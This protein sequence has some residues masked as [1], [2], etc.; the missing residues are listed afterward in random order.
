MIQNTNEEYLKERLN[1]I[2][3]LQ[4]MVAEKQ[5]A[6]KKLTMECTILQDVADQRMND[7][8][9]KES[10]TFNY[11]EPF[12]DIWNT[13]IT[14]KKIKEEKNVNQEDKEKFGTWT[15]EREFY[16]SLVKSSIFDEEIIETYK[17]ELVNILMWC[18]QDGYEFHY[19]I[20]NK[21][22]IFHIALKFDRNDETGTVIEDGKFQFGYKDGEYS[23]I[24]VG[25]SY[26]ES[27]I[28]SIATK[29]IKNNCGLKT[30]VKKE[31]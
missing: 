22:V 18:Y 24:I 9:L 28:K 19:K 27:E 26:F 21:T 14:I 17:P 10:R 6:L 1:S 2:K 13:F 12:L 11:T 8:L 23:Q 29:W 5:L 3:E 16:L 20:G 25:S 7:F 30:K 15:K 4:G 31:E